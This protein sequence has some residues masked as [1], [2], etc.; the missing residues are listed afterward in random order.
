MDRKISDIAKNNGWKLVKTI[1]KTETFIFKKEGIQIVYWTG[2]GSCSISIKG[3]PQK[4]IRNLWVDEIE[5]LF[6]NPD[7]FYE[8]GYQERTI[9]NRSII[10]S[11]NR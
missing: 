4:Y 8:S 2:K 3:K 9:E 5:L 10:T 1:E 7:S 6:K 11:F